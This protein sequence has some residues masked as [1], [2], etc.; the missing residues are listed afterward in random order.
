[1]KVTERNFSIAVSLILRDITRLRRPKLPVPK[2]YDTIEEATVPCGNT[3]F[4][5]EIYLP[6]WIHDNIEHIWI[7]HNI[8][9]VEHAHR[10]AMKYHREFCLNKA[11]E[12]QSK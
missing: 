3:L 1:M 9:I 6:Q 8:E 5:E 2:S 4:Y 11:C 12:Y 10:I 7:V